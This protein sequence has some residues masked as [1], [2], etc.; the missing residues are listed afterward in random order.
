MSLPGQ[1]AE[2][3]NHM[4]L[5]QNLKVPSPCSQHPKADWSAPMPSCT[6][7]LCYKKSGSTAVTSNKLLGIIAFIY[8]LSCIGEG[9]G[10]PL[11]CSCLENLRDGG[12]RWLLSMGLHRVGHD[13]SDLAAAAAAERLNWKLKVKSE[14]EVTQSCPTLSDPM[15]CSLP[16]S[17]PWDLPGKSTGVGCHC[18]LWFSSLVDFILIRMFWLFCTLQV[19]HSAWMKCFD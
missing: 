14:S 17:H 12:A 19:E 2:I 7:V 15:D 10:N 11:Q 18:L 13:W 9:N 6:S 4:C 1:V 5:T 3:P 8:A 16:G